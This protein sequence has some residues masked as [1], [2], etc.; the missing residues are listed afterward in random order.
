MIYAP[1]LI[2]TM[3]RDKHFIRCVESLRKN[4]WAKYTDVYI[5]LDYPPNKKYWNGYNSICR[6]LDGEF[7]EFAS[8]NVLKREKNYGAYK[9]MKELREMVLLRYD[10]FIRTDDDTEFS[11]NFLEYMNKGLQYSE[12][13]NEVIAV[14]G[15]SYPLKWKLKDNC[16][17]FYVDFISPMW[18]IGFLKERYNMA[19][20]AICNGFN[21]MIF[22]TGE[23]RKF[24]YTDARLN[25]LVNGALSDDKNDL[26]RRVTDIGLAVALPAK[27][28][29]VLTP[30]LS[31]VRN[32]GFDGTGE[33]C[34]NIGKNENKQ[35][36]RTYPYTKQRIDNQL[37][38]ELYVD[39]NLNCDENRKII[40]VFD[41]RKLSVKL[42]MRAKIIGYKLIQKYYNKLKRTKNN[43]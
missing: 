10:R 3:S 22:K 14:A 8:F 43:K 36:A 37:T 2:P 32:W 18:G 40:N 38:Y 4:T 20:Q 24:K 7:N 29:V 1:V 16:N 26:T 34:Q 31:K 13:H 30:V 25:D 6:Y 19:N 28:W 9:N 23:W 12:N 33:Y 11:P 21:E 5:G 42:K 39:N 17:A 27:K 15:Y 41:S 35:F